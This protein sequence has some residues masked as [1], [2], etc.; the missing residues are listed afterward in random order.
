MTTWL[1]L[2][3]SHARQSPKH[4]SLAWQV[5]AQM[6]LSPCLTAALFIGDSGVLL[7]MAES[8]RMLL[9]CDDAGEA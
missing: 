3:A 6:Q 4:A 2:H 7:N 1:D 9:W 5:W 8:P